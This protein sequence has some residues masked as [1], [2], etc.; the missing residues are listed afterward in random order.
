MK[1]KWTVYWSLRITLSIMDLQEDHHGPPQTD[2]SPSTEHPQ[3]RSWVTNSKA[4]PQCAVHW[5]TVAVPP[6]KSRSKSL[7]TVALKLWCH[8]NHLENLLNQIAGPHPPV[9]D[10][11][12]LSWSWEFVFLIGSQARP[13]LLVQEK[14]FREYC[15][16][17][18]LSE[19]HIYWEGNTYVA[20]GVIRSA[21][22]RQ[23]CNFQASFSDSGSQLWLHFKNQQ[24]TFLKSPMSKSHPQAIKLE[25]PQSHWWLF[26]FSSLGDS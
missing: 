8:Q 25:H 16:K 11:V 2:L 6:E 4:S 5:M 14:H 15:P 19:A 24:V 18:S 3:P 20:P 22:N 7:K 10:S 1:L 17:M 9:S 12:S 13:M 23:K 26:F 21:F